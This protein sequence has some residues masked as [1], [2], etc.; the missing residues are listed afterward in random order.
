MTFMGRDGKQYVVIAAGGPGDTDR[1]GTELFPQKLVA[2]ALSDRTASP[3]SAAAPVNSAR[4]AAPATAA[5]FARAEEGK[6]LTEQQCTTCHGMDTIRAAGRTPE[7]WAMVVN[8]MIGLGAPI[9]D[10]QAKAIVD[11]LSRD[12]PPKR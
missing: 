9:T 12:F 3:S 8:E 5:A 2:F 1:G 7:A 6:G 11:F 10:D 4:P